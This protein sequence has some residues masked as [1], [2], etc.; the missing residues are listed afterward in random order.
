MAEEEDDNGPTEETAQF[1]PPELWGLDYQFNV[2]NK[3]YIRDILQMKE[4]QMFPGKLCIPLRKQAYSNILK[5][6]PSK[7]EKKKN[8][9]KIKK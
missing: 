4:Y 3:M 1:F 2:Y 5:I 8:N 7:T 9:K 6:L